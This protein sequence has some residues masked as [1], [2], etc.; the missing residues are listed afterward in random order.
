M[1]DSPQLGMTRRPGPPMKQLSKRLNVAW[2]LPA[3]CSILMPG[4]SI[5]GTW[6]TV[7]VEPIGAAFPIAHI[8]FTEDGRYT[9][10]GMIGTEEVTHTGRYEWVMSTVRLQ[11]AGVSDRQCTAR[12][13][14]D[15]RLQLSCESQ[16]RSVTGTLILVEE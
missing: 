10:T 9:A 12:R 16:D 1:T 4:C 14:I 11:P 3:I 15:G 6:R 8:S 13:R 7:E 2:I 5:H